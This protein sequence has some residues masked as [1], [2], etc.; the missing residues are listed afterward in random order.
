METES[1]RD[2]ITQVVF[3]VFFAIL[4]YF[5]RNEVQNA[6]DYTI[7]QP[8]VEIFVIAFL[9]VSGQTVI[10]VSRYYMPHV[11]VNGFSGS[12][13]GRP[14]Y[15]K[16]VYGFT[17]A[18]FNTGEYL[19][20]FHGKGKLSTLIVPASSL[21]RSGRNYVSLTFVKRFNYLKLPN[22]V[23]SYLVENSNDYNTKVVYYGKYS[24]E[25]LHQDPQVSDHE[26]QIE[27]LNQQVNLRND[28]LE[29]RNDVLIEHKKFADELSGTKT[30]L[31]SFLRRKKTADEEQ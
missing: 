13:L 14:V 29:N 8:I 11:T 23:Y 21:R 26:L 25:F 28:L 7:N 3:F 4:Y 27:S 5:F 1:D 6:G 24:E 12:I 10:W 16:D 30:G 31:F 9:I 20:P 22:V 17:W 19:E 18:I 2:Y 15:L